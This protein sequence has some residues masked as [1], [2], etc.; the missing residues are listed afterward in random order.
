MR[1]VQ[2]LQKHL[3]VCAN[4]LLLE[5]HFVVLSLNY[6][7]EYSLPSDFNSNIILNT[8][9]K[10]ELES[11]KAKPNYLEACCNDTKKVLV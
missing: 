4:C 8:A 2:Q 6:H 10:C 11:Y 9:L 1:A 3:L 7:C 5:I